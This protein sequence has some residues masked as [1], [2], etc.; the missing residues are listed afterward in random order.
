M[1]TLSVS[2]EFN[3]RPELRRSVMVDMSARFGMEPTAFEA[4]L[5]ATVVPQKCSREDLAAFLLV[6][7]DYG[8]NPVTRE[9]YAFPTRA[10]GIQPI[11]SV[12]GWCHIINS[13]PQLDGIE[14]DDEFDDDGNFRAITARI[15]R[16]DRAHPITVT[17]YMAECVRQTEPCQKWPRRMLRHKALIQCAR[18]AFG[19]SGIIEPDEADRGVLPQDAPRRP[20]PPRAPLLPPTI[21]E[22]VVQSSAAPAKPATRPPAPG[23]G[24]PNDDLVAAPQPEGRDAYLTFVGERFAA[25]SMISE[26]DSAWRLYVEPFKERLP[27]AFLTECSEMFGNWQRKIEDADVGVS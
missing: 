8:L 15:W 3:S 9:I 4:T 2:P 18:Y 7:R 22:E 27:P 16:K 17:E 5:R 26:L 21:Q 23:G 10:G 25:A 14:F 11:V 13:H 20:P 1:T 6:A 12:D 24:T 19:F